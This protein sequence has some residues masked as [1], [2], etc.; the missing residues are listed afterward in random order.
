MKRR[1]IKKKS[2]SFRHSSLRLHNGQTVKVQWKWKQWINFNERRKEKK[3]ERKA[4][5][6]FARTLVPVTEITRSPVRLFLMPVSLTQ[7]SERREWGKRSL[8]T[9]LLW[10]ILSNPLM[11]S[12]LITRVGLLFLPA[13]LIFR[14]DVHLTG[15]FCEWWRGCHRER[16]SKSDQRIKGLF[17]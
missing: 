12:W 7:S 15:W 6:D 9:K 1:T 14:V 16:V 4:L 5:T 11:R 8:A 3:N 13:I 2:A 10:L 17:R